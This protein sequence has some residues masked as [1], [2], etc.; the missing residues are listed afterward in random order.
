MH[1][2]STSVLHAYKKN[3]EEFA[4]TSGVRQGCVLAHTPSNLF[5]DAVI[6]M[7]IDEHLEEG[8]GCELYFTLTL[9]SLVIEG[10]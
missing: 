1:D 7:A 3:S 9:S 2:Q 8:G 5:F 4:V 6:R 10:R